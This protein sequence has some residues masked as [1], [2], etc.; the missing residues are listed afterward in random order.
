MPETLPPPPW[1]VGRQRQAFAL[2]RDNARGYFVYPRPY[3]LAQTAETVQRPPTPHDLALAL[4]CARTLAAYLE[5]WRILPDLTAELIELGD[6]I[7][8]AG[9]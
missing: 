2:L 4:D 6:T 1:T 8:G 3:P 7:E 9:L 5:G